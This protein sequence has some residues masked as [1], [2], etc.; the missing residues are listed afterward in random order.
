M[1]KLKHECGVIAFF[2]KNKED[3]VVNKTIDAL[4]KLQHRGQDSCGIAYVED[5][6]IKKKSASGLIRDNFLNLEVKSSVSIA[7]TMYATCGKVNIS[8]AQPYLYNN[9]ALCFN[10]TVYNVSKYKEILKENDFIF[11]TDSDAE[12]I[13]KWLFLKLKKESFK[14]SL[15]EIRDVLNNDFKMSA[16]SLLILLKDKIFAFKDF[17]SFRPLVFI[18]TETEYILSSEDCAYLGDYIK[19]FEIKAAQGI[20]ISEKGCFLSD[21]NSCNNTKK[22]VFEIVY[23]AHKKSKVFNIDVK[24][25]RVKLG[26][27]LAK[28]DDIDADVV[29]PVMNSGFWGAYGYS[30]EKNIKLSLAI[31]NN[32]NVLRTFI[33]K[34]PKRTIVIDEKYSIVKNKIKGKEVIVVDDSIVRGNT[35]KKIVLLLRQNGVKKIHFRLFSPPIINCCFWGVDIP[36]KEELLAYNFKSKDNETIAKE[37]GV[38]SIKFISKELFFSVFSE[39]EW[40]N[41]CFTEHPIIISPQV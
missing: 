13:L 21:Y 33:E 9:V 26:M 35:I 16:F 25:A 1:T 6:I 5:N 20:E 22:C 3:N 31:K 38:N 28:E 10:G 12:I 36:Q 17:F 23:F 40:C 34:E 7:H 2:S 8:N 18:E 19:K 41:N 24:S 30:K 37:L 14:W 32:R 27:L 29:I 15:N 4:I 11:E 39:N